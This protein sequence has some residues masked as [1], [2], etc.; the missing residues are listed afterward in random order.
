MSTAEVFDL[1]RG[2]DILWSFLALHD[3]TRNWIRGRDTG[4]MCPKLWFLETKHHLPQTFSSTQFVLLSKTR[5]FLPVLYFCVSWKPKMFLVPQIFPP[6]SK[7]LCQRTGDK[8]NRSSLR[9]QILSETARR[10]SEIV[11]AGDSPGSFFVFRVGT[12]HL[13]LW[14]SVALLFVNKAIPSQLM[15]SG[16]VRF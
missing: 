5:N 6:I 2:N 9:F 12:K 3:I 10:D 14:Q 15:I 1:I 16:F 13:C 8:I 4:M 7:H 11:C